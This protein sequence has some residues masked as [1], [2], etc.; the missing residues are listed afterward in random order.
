VISAIYGVLVAMAQGD[1]KRLVAFSSVNHMGY[2]MLG[3]AVAAVATAAPADRSAAA[4]G[5]V[6]QMVAHGLITGALFFLVGMLADRTGTREIS[7]LSGLWAVL[8]RYGAVL[9]F[10]MFASLGLPALAGF[11]AEVQIV[12]GA[13]GV[14]R[15]A[16]VGAGWVWLAA[17]I[18]RLEDFGWVCRLRTDAHLNVLMETMNITAT[19]AAIGIR[20][21]QLS[22]MTIWTSDK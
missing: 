3:I 13:L 4:S 5:A 17:I 11:V 22:R 15:W 2:V 6:Y 21:T 16:A 7:K 14:F 19:S 1:L 18:A 20:H 9:A 10:T 12:L 8:P